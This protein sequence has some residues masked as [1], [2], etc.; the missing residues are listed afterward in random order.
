[1]SLRHA[2]ASLMLAAL[3]WTAQAD[4]DTSDQPVV[5]EVE[6]RDIRLPHF[7][8]R[9][10]EV[11]L[12]GGAYSTQ[13]FGASAL[14]GVRLSYHITEDWFVEGAYGKTTVSDDAFKR[15]LPGGIFTPGQNTLQYTSLS[16]GLNL[17]PGEVFIGRKRAL[18][19]SLFVLGGGGTT[20]FN[21][22]RQQTFNLGLGMKVLFADRFAWRVDLRDHLF[23]VDLLGKRESTHNLELTS[24]LSFIF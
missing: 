4:T 6:R 10:F 5:P 21:G 19:F 13:S 1:M 8:S 22:Q 3:P 9:D 20:K 12:Y 15:V 11:G 24:G 18:P 7:P 17:L 2:L 14:G 16:A 23:S